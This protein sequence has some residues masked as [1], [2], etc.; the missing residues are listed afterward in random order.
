[1]EAQIETG[2]NEKHV[3]IADVAA[4]V[5][6]DKSAVYQTLKGTGRISNERRLQI[7]KAAEE[8]GYEPDPIAQRLARGR[9][10]DTIAIFSLNLDR[11][12]ITEHIRLIQ[13]A[14]S[15]Q[16]YT[17]PIHAYWFHDFAGA[18]D[19]ALVV[20]TLRKERPR[21]IVVFTPGLREGSLAELRQ[22]QR[23]GGILV[24]YD[25]PIPID[26]DQVLF[27]E[28][29]NTLQATNYLLDIGHR[30]IGF[31]TQGYGRDLDHPRYHAWKDAL[32][33]RGIGCDEGLT[34]AN[35]VYEEAGHKAAEWFL[36]L[37]DRPT[38]IVVLN[39][40]TAA[41]F[42]GELVRAG[43]KLPEELSIVGHDGTP[44]SAYGLL[45]LTTATRP[46]EMVA[47][48]TVSFLLDRVARG[49]SGPPRQSSI[50]GELIVREST[51]PPRLPNLAPTDNNSCG[52]G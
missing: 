31:V 44:V 7:R 43:L 2:S 21:A 11:G 17:V 33:A 1:M 30:R 26:C 42:A 49:Y 47:A 19:Q 39:D 40:I 37:S 52:P 36:A 20:K 50:T 41:T 46:A 35:G 48:Q 28:Y 25:T 24:T 51:A 4:A 5:G 23:E 45:P 14:L 12:I 16:G 34:F 8:L 10:N 15:L 32:R 6:V 18:K 13:E 29:E 3:T 9:A 22:F 27:S 38:G